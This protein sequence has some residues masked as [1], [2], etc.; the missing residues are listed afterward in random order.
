MIFIDTHTHLYVDQFDND[1]EDVIYKANAAGIN[2][3]F[4]PAIDSETH[5]RQLNVEKKYPNTCFSMMGLHPCSVNENVEKELAIVESYLQQ[6]SFC[7]IG[8]IGLDYYWDTSFA[9]QQQQAF[10]TQMDWALQYNIPINIH[11]RKAIQQTISMVKPY[12]AK[13]LTGIFHCFGDDYNTAKQIINMGFY[14]GIGGVL[15]Y[16]KAGLQETLKKV[17]LEHIVLE[18][19]APYLTPVPF[20]GKRNQSSYIKII[21]EKLAEVKGESIEEIA[22]VTTENAKKI[23]KMD[24]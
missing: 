24:L 16:P 4:L 2:H 18:T 21:A 19:D 14:L 10:A 20:R 15:T 23:Y 22:W 9:T 6:R 13:G 7:A 17:D 11:T 8:E 1:L 5:E 12:A 3:F